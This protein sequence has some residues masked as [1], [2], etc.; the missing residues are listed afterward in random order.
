MRQILLINP[1]IFPK[2]EVLVFQAKKYCQ[3]EYNIRKPTK[4]GRLCGMTTH[5][6][7]STRLCSSQKSFPWLAVREKTMASKKLQKKMFCQRK[8]KDNVHKKTTVKTS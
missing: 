2:V 6:D 7:Q 5:I 1:A 3:H 8:H 4:S